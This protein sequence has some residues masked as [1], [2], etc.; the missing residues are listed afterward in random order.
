MC[1]DI[2]QLTAEKRNWG[3]RGK[4]ADGNTI[5]IITIYELM[6]CKECECA[7]YYIHVL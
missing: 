2:E 7:L 1:I 6:T 4:E 3:F 5:F